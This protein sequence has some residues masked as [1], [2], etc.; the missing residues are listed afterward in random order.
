M[1]SGLEI[2]WPRVFS[3]GGSDQRTFDLDLFP[4]V[5]NAQ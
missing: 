2:S 3:L 4:V 1:G 5:A